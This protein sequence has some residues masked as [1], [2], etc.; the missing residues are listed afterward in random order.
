[1]EPSC[2]RPRKKDQV[3]F[4]YMQIVFL[5]SFVKDAIFSLNYGI[6]IYKKSL[7]IKGKKGNQ[8][9]VYMWTYISVLTFI[10]LANMSSFCVYIMLFFVLYLMLFCANIMLCLCSI[11]CNQVWWYLQQSFYC[12]GLFASLDSFLLLYKFYDLKKNFFVKNCVRIWWGLS[13]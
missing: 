7:H 5:I 4:F 13:L 1:M 10:P 9:A 8:V 3:S 2:I 12:S 6:F 11:I